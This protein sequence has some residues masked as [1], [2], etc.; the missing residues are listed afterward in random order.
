MTEKNNATCSICGKGYRMCLSCQDA[1]KLSPWKKHT[2]TSEHYKI[3]QILRGFSTG[4]YDKQEARLKL[5]MVDLSDL[6]SFRTNIKNLINNIM[7][8]DEVISLDS[9]DVVKNEN[10]EV[11]VIEEPKTTRKR[12]SSKV[13]E[14]E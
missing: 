8:V 3:Y 9:D 1:I 13:V 14:T 7:K 2:D 6:D 4:V 11:L 12:K 10:E 5:Q